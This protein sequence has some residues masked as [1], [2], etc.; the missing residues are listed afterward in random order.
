[1][2]MFKVLFFFPLEIL[3]FLPSAVFTFVSTDPSS[4]VLGGGVPT[5]ILNMT[6]SLLAAKRHKLGC[7]LMSAL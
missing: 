2:L 5:T 6:F 7:Q 1:M 4:C 3:A